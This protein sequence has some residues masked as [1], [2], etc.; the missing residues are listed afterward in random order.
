MRYLGVKI[1][2]E[3][4]DALEDTGRPKSEVVREALEAHLGV[5]REIPYQDDIIKLIDERI[6]FNAG[7]TTIKPGLSKSK[8]EVK[9]DPRP[10]ADKAMIKPELNESEIEVK[11]ELNERKTKVKLE[12]NQDKTGVKLGLNEGKTTTKSA[13]N[14]DKT[15]V[16]QVLQVIKDFH[17]RGIEPTAAE[18]AEAVGM[19]SRPLG[20]IMKEA[21]VQ[22]QNVHRSGVKARRY[23]FELKEK[24][25]GML[26]SGELEK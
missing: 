20:R 2:D 24:I 25:E 7:K 5:K 17:N 1:P 18:V 3:L 21:G 23:T 15:Q 4:A 19:E 6:A 26:E 13:L 12:L 10:N 16:K 14:D 8:T 11:P 9:T 22:A